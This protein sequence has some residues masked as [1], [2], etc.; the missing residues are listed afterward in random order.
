[1]MDHLRLAEHHLATLDRSMS[2]RE[3]PNLVAERGILPIEKCPLHP[4]Q[5]QGFRLLVNL[6]EL[7]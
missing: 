6:A 7:R 4:T 1:M 2:L 3:L 5:F